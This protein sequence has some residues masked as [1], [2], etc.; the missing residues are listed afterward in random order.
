M[1]VAKGDNI[2]S[3]SY[4]YLGNKKPPATIQNVETKLFCSASTL[5]VQGSQT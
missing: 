2:T 5:E 4:G 1:S 3:G